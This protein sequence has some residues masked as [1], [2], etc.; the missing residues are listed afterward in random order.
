MGMDGVELVIEIEERFGVS[1]P[2]QDLEQIATVGDLCDYLTARAVELRSRPCATAWFFYRFRRVLL[3][4]LPAPRRAVRP[5]ASLASL[6]PAT[7]RKRTWRAL[8]YEFEH[9]LP[10]LQ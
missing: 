8:Q 1:F 9:R 6:I 5:R 2:D 3:E 10:A 7:R 4:E